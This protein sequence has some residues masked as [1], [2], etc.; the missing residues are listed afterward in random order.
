MIP[1]NEVTQLSA[2]HVSAVARS[3]SWRLGFIPPPGRVRLNTPP[4]VRLSRFAGSAAG[5]N[6]HAVRR[7]RLA[8]LVKPPDD[9][10]ACAHLA[11][12]QAA[13]KPTI[14]TAIEPG[15]NSAGRDH[16]RRG[17]RRG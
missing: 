4:G 6:R 10:F 3:R 8:I 12:V 7:S 1:A 11:P 16:K 15:Q 17:S 2:G 14:D 5:R 13:W 9:G